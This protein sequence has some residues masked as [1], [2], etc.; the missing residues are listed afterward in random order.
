MLENETIQTIKVKIEAYLDTFSKLEHMFSGTILISIDGI[1][2][3]NKGYGMSNYELNVPNT[4]DTIYKIGSITKQ[5]TALLIMH[6]LEKGRL[7]LNQT[8]DNFIS[9]YPNG[10]K[11][12][13]HHLLTHSS[14]IHNYTMDED[15]NIYMRQYHTLNSLIERFKNKP[16]DFE[17]GTK[18]SY[19][20]SGYILLGYIIEEIT[21]KTYSEYLKE[22]IFKKLL[23]KNS[24][25][26]NYSDLIK[27]RANGYDLVDGNIQNCDFIDDSVVDAAGAIY[28]TT[29]DLHK[30]NSDL[31]NDTLISKKST[32]KMM[33]KHNKIDED[34]YY[35]Y[36]IMVWSRK[37][38]EKVRNAIS[39]DGG[40][41][42][43]L[44]S[45]NL[46]PED[47]VEIIILSNLTNDS[48][49]EISFKLR[50]IIF[51]II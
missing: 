15:I 17:P 37:Y 22:F 24:G 31:L 29:G 45:N 13:I 36:G 27:N 21:G 25:Y 28:S 43:F 42:G 47:K 4:V 50:E 38:G 20:N 39:H 30:W 9:D 48:K 18:Y 34:C 1:I 7:D 2:I 46:Y 44:S 11:V 6:L 16:F 33:G 14:G 26:N 49:D 10:N 35:G 32:M 40:T 51:D 19:S 5:F 8:L 3:I 23:M 12:T 41:L